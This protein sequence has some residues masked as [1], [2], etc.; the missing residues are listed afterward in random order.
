MIKLHGHDSLASLQESLRAQGIRKDHR[1]RKAAR[2]AERA[3]L[4]T[5]ASLKPPADETGA[6]RRTGP[7]IRAL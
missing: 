1:A 6:A 3:G 7:T 4:A 2:R 5:G